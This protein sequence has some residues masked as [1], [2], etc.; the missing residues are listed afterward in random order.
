VTKPG[1]GKTVKL[2]SD[3]S[4]TPSASIEQRVFGDDDP[5]I[6]Y[7]DRCAAYAVIFNNDRVAS[8]KGGQNYFLPGGGMHAGETPEETLIRE[9]R[10]EL[11]RGARLIR[12]IGRATQYFYAPSDGCHYR[13]VATFFLAELTAP[14]SGEAEY[15][16]EWSM[17]EEIDFLFFHA[18]HAWAVRE[19]LRPEEPEIRGQ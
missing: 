13:M 16:L 8:V 11:G 14:I 15:R 10:E 6:A 18:C 2:R 3:K 7:K 9:I 12:E 4:S 5:R 19:A 17:L 1:H